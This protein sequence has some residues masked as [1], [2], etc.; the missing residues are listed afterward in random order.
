M[1]QPRKLKKELFIIMLGYLEQKKLNE[2]DVVECLKEC[3]E[4]YVSN[5][6][7]ETVDAFI[8]AKMEC[9]RSRL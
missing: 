9:A 5:G 4:F 8:L 1:N 3:I 6:D 2:R 7:E